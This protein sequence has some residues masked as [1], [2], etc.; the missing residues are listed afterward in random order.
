MS[1]AEEALEN[2]GGIVASLCTEE[3]DLEKCW[4]DG[5]IVCL[6]EFFSRLLADAGV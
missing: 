4:S 3:Q 1:F 2:G 5:S 6:N